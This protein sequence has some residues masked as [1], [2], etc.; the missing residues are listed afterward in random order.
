MDVISLLS[1]DNNNSDGE[2]ARAADAVHVPAASAQGRARRQPV[3]RE[4]L[5]RQRVDDGRQDDR[6]GAVPHPRDDY[7]EL[8]GDSSDSSDD[9]AEHR[10]VPPPHDFIDLSGDNSNDGDETTAVPPPHQEPP[11]Q[12]LHI[13]GVNNI[14]QNIIQ[15]YFNLYAIAQ[16]PTNTQPTWFQNLAQ[17][18]ES[19][20]QN[21]VVRRTCRESPEFMQIVNLRN[22]HP[23]V[24]EDNTHVSG[25][26]LV[27]SPDGFLPRLE[28]GKTL[29]I[30]SFVPNTRLVSGHTT[31]N[32]NLGQRHIVDEM[33]T[34][35]VYEVATRVTMEY[36]FDRP[37]ASVLSHGS[38][39]LA[40]RMP[41]CKFCCSV[42]HIQLVD[43]FNIANWFI[44]YIIIYILLHQSG[45]IQLAE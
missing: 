11:Q 43:L 19:I 37:T 21:D 29:G 30:L 12:I 16:Q 39:V 3:S 7:I 22:T 13:L 41:L 36:G 18:P 27:H 32:A 44:S 33:S 34:G 10:A 2:D 35:F 6:R 9:D 20:L 23:R 8:S 26:R 40:N 28:C 24:M 14:A 31:D 25:G 1:D 17:D 45:S 5:I 42:S 15:Q 4:R 38:I